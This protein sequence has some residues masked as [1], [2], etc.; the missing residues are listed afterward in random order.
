MQV[1]AGPRLARNEH[2]PRAALLAP[3]RGS[4][5]A[6]DGTTLARSTPHGRTYPLGAAL[7]H[8]VGYASPRYGTSGLEAAF[9]TE[10]AARPL[11]NDPVAQIQAIL[12]RR[13]AAPAL[14]GATIVTTLDP[15]VERVL[16][17]GL[18]AYP[19]RGGRRARSA[20]RVRFS[21]WRAC[22]ASLRQD[23]R[24][25]F[26]RCVPMRKVRCWIARST[27]ST[28][29][30]RRSRSSSR[31]AAARGG[32]R[33]DVIDVRRSG[34]SAR[35][36]LR[37]AR[38]RG[39]GDGDARS[40]GRLRLIEQCR[41]RA[42]R[43]VA[44]RRRLVSR[45]RPL[46]AR[47]RPRFRAARGARSLADARE[48]EPEHSRA[49]RFRSGGLA[50]HAATDGA[51]RGHDRERR[52]GTASGSRARHSARWPRPARGCRRCARDAGI[53]RGSPPTYGR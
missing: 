42:D 8:T 47:A 10:L 6:R 48:R 44:R 1:V 4:I 11:G 36:Q 19:A 18:R 23:S 46:A 12:G 5:V 50:G 20:N 24:P 21:R 41:F 32:R 28:R 2:N 17:D 22:R 13:A 39:R 29:P 43:A 15:A 14:P 52:R 9:D 45:G 40:H 35:G 7:A 25:I 33:H 31:A 26:A 51:R 34:R 30:A 53:R 49:T 37:R 38:Q 16:Y 27:V 3:Y